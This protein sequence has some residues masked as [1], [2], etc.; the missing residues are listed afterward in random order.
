MGQVFQRTYRRPDKGLRTCETWTIRYYRHGRA[1]QEATRL[2]RKGDALNLL[3]GA[4][5]VSPDQPVGVFSSGR[6]GA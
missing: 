3:G 6:E 5:P 2:T 1:H 4:A